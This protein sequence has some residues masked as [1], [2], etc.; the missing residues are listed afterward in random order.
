MKKCLLGLAVIGLV[1][2]SARTFAQDADTIS[3]VR[4]LLV[5]FNVTGTDVNLRSAG[6][7][8]SMYYMGRL[9]AHVPKL[10]IEALIIQQAQMMTSADFASEAVRCGHTFADRGREI[11]RIGNDMMELEKARR[12]PSGK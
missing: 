4:C 9:D 8:L 7:A 5:G 11:K 2:S 10:D 6:Q 12:A 3:D 1:L